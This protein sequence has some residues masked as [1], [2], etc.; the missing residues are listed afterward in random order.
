MGRT[1]RPITDKGDD[2][3]RLNKPNLRNIRWPLIGAIAVGLIVAGFGGTQYKN[4]VNSNRETVRVL[5]PAKNIPP[6]TA[7]RSG[8]F[9]WETIAKG[10]E[11]PGTVTDTEQLK[12][13]IS[14]STLYQ[15]EQIKIE[16]V[17]DASL[18]E[19]KQ[20]V[21]A[22]IDITRSLGGWL[23]PGDLVD[24]WWIPSDSSMDTPGAG[25]QKVAPNAIVLD[26]R[27]S[28]GK[29]IYQSTVQAGIMQS[30]LN[31]PASPPAVA[32]LAV[33]TED[34]PRVVGGASPNSQNVILAK[35]FNLEVESIGETDQARE[36]DSTAD[37]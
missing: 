20:L 5:V 17:G 13:K 33:R 31:A 18:A 1:V 10:G 36:D 25:W 14:L 4:Y 7:L 8:D 34:V 37:D 16:R 27:D 28:S 2:T 21:S 22:N 15:G 23:A 3:L 26:I 24:V 30:A 19:G 32:I 35:K 6:Y 11:T 12:G 9:K 29:S